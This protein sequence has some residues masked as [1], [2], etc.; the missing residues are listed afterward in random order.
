VHAHE[1]VLNFSIEA[2]NVNGEERHSSILHEA[3]AKGDAIVDSSPV[4]QPGVKPADT[5]ILRS[6]SIEMLMK[7]GGKEIESLRTDGP[8]Q[9]EF[10]P[11]Q[12]DRAHRW[13]DG[14]RIQIAYGA[15]NAIDSFRATNAKTRTEK[16][17]P[18]EKR[19][20]KDGK[21]APPLP[22]ALT[23]SDQLTAKF[24]P[25]TNELATLEQAGHFQYEEGLRHATAAKAFLE[26]SSNKITL[27]DAARVWDD[28]GTTSAD[29]ILLNQANGDM[30]ATG[31]V[32]STRQPDQQKDS[33]KSSL[34]DQSKP[35]QA[36]ADR[37]TTEENNLKI[38]YIGHAVLWQEANRIQANTVD[39]DRDEETL[40]AAGNVVSQLVYKQDD[41]DSKTEQASQT[42]ADGQVRLQPVAL[43]DKAAKKPA[44]KKKAGPPI[45]TIVKA[46]DMLYKDDD[47]LAY[48]TGG[49]SLVRDHMN[50][51]SKELRAF[52]T[53]DDSS[54]DKSDDSGT[55]LDHA[56]ADGN[57]K[58]VQLTGGRTRTGTSEHCE[59]YPKQNK[60][61]LNGG[62][63]KMVD[64]KK[65]TTVGQQL[66]Y[67]SDS[68]H[69][70]VDGLPK[71]P[72]VS[73]MEKHK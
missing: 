70:I 59:Y 61:I 12:P 6:Q 51:V 15:Q 56:F 20:G 37:M 53:N 66:T 22:P 58:V 42:S 13:M 52:L 43:V 2:E 36:R 11:N 54:K 17:T 14:D 69:V 45:F 41:N 67:Y 29:D 40:H 31:H 46:P 21:P 39:I 28:T 10:K 30:D 9:L 5:R 24:A 47:R 8:G 71:N 32:A 68:D 35:L 34:L 64:T 60:V 16:P 48:Y 3:F 26:Q 72:V 63:A 19:V 4:T 44:P 57:V 62:L 18:P 50:V 25:L 33:Q 27:N 65:G 73:D 55:S 7:A 38:H 23:S 1:A 49:V